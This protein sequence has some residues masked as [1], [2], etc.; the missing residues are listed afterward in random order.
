MSVTSI[1]VKD[2][3]LNVGLA[4]AFFWLDRNALDLIKLCNCKSD[5]LGKV[6]W[7]QIH[8]LLSENC[9]EHFNKKFML[10]ICPIPKPF[11]RNRKKEKPA[12]QRFFLIR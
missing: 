6:F 2:R 8:L 4:S 9:I 5:R 12:V 11:F 1:S 10:R 3:V 7:V